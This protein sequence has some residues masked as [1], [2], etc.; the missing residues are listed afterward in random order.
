MTICLTVSL[1][2]RSFNALPTSPLL[3]M[4][5]TAAWLYKEAKAAVCMAVA[6]ETVV[7][8]AV[9]VAAVPAAAAVL[10][11]EAATPPA[12]VAPYP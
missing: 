4:M 8:A 11:P 1:V 5:D 6:V 2:P 7:A 12:A 10:L 9:V 3:L